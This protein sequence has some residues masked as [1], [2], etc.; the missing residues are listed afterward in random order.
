MALIDRR[1]FLVTVGCGAAAMPQAASACA[2]PF[3]SDAK[4]ET[5]HRLSAEHPGFAYFA[6]LPGHLG[7]PFAHLKTWFATAD[8]RAA[9]NDLQNCCDIACVVIGCV[10]TSNSI[11]DFGPYAAIARAL[12]QPTTS[13]TIGFDTVSAHPIAPHGATLA[14]TMPRKSWR[15][16]HDNDKIAI[17]SAAARM[18]T[19]DVN[20]VTKLPSV[21]P[22][23]VG[24]SAFDRIAEAVIAEQ[25]NHD[26][27]TRRI[28]A[29]Y[30]SFKA[31][32]L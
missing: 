19:S 21:T 12:G 14:L 10:A 6:G 23:I 18:C 9:W 31:A 22:S 17:A 7:M 1:N 3:D 20:F 5:L 11:A 27:L 16:L 28:N 25:A 8:A 4:I 13:K 30:F 26:D 24:N 32:L 2:S 15:K 29:H